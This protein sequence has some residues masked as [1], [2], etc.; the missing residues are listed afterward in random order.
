MASPRF[1]RGGGWCLTKCNQKWLTDPREPIWTN[2]HGF[3]QSLGGHHCHVGNFAD[4]STIAM[5]N[6]HLYSFL[7]GK[8]SINWTCSSIFIH[9]PLHK[10]SVRWTQRAGKS[11]GHPGRCPASHDSESSCI[12]KAGIL[13]FTE[14]SPSPPRDH[15]PPLFAA[16]CFSLAGQKTAESCNSSKHILPRLSDTNK[17]DWSKLTTRKSPILSAGSSTNHMK[18]FIEFRF[19]QCQILWLNPLQSSHPGIALQSEL[20]RSEAARERCLVTL[21]R[22]PMNGTCHGPIHHGFHGSG[23]L[24]STPKFNPWNP[25]HWSVFWIMMDPSPSFQLRP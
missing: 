16:T 21:P 10:L 19:F 5:E 17:L 13:E 12:W 18:M 2:P 22:G 23:D 25:W 15:A 9:V 20:R 1:Q 7:R 3:L 14:H 24:G 11:P 4:K 8:S 6:D